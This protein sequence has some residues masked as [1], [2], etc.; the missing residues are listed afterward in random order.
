MMNDE[1]GTMKEEEQTS[2]FLR[3]P[4]IV[5]RFASLGYDVRRKHI[6]IFGDGTCGMYARV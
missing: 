1:R 6:G 2:L 3:S 5:H 4:F